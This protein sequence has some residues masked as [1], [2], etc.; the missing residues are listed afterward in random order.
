ME[1]LTPRLTAGRLL[2]QTAAV[3][4][5]DALL[6]R[7]AALLLRHRITEAAV[8][9]AVSTAPEALQAGV[10]E[11]RSGVPAAAHPT[12]VAE[13]REDADSQLVIIFKRKE[14]EKVYSIR[15]AGVV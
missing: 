5:T 2:R 14:Y 13:C 15:F 11:A 4:R 7:E 6:L 9:A 3:L 8:E 10:R 1:G 12:A